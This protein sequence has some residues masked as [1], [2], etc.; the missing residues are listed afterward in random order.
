MTDPTVVR[1]AL[2]DSCG[3]VAV[4]RA[5][6]GPG[7][8]VRGAAE[9]AVAGV[10][11]SPAWAVDLSGD[12]RW[13]AVDVPGSLP[14][15]AVDHPDDEEGQLVARVRSMPRVVVGFRELTRAD[16]PAVVAWQSQ[17]HVARWQPLR[18]AGSEPR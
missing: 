11:G 4:R 2:R 18:E 15:A 14:D 6:L 5:A 1:V 8:S 16:L 9:A 17:P 12:R 7:A 13:L 10:G 3:A